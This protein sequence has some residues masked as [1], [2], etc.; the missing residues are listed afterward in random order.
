MTTEEHNEEGTEEQIEDLEAPAEAQRDVEGGLCATPTNW[1]A[2][3]TCI[4]TV[5]DC[6]RLSLQGVVREK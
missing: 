1:C 5:T 4:D 2:P 3:P 6:I